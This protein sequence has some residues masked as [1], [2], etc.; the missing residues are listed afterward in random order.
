MA[1]FDESACLVEQRVGVSFLCFNV[2]R[3]WRRV[4]REIE[5]RG[6]SGGESQIFPIAGLLVKMG[7]ENRVNYPYWSKWVMVTI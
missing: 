5:F 6:V 4:D 2:G 7:D 1:Q 3:I